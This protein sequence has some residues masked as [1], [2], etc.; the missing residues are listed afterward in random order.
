MALSE[1]EELEL[2]QL[3]KA[4]QGGKNPSFQNQIPDVIKQAGEAALASS[5]SNLTQKFMQT[6]PAVMQKMGGAALP[7]VGGA[8]GGAP[9]AAGGEFLR[10]MTGTALAPE[11]VPQTPL[12]RFASVVGAGAA[13]EPKILEAIPGVPAVKEMASGLLSKVGKG[14]AKAGQTLT[15]AKADVLTQAAKQGLSTYAAPSIPKAQE[16]FGQALGPEGRAAL[17]QSASEA[18]DSSLSKA[19]QLAT[20][21]GTK[22]EKGEPVSAIEALQAK[23]ATDQIISATSVTDKVSRRALFDWKSRFDD[24]LSSQNGPLKSASNTYRQAVVK[25]Q[26]LSPT[27]LNKSGEPSAFLPMLIGHGMMGK[28]IEGGL[29]MLTGTSPA[30]W[31]LGATAGGSAS[32]GLL[33]LGQQPEIRQAL[34]GILQKI[35][36]SR[37]N[38]QAQ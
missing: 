11:T 35:M 28:G 29:G 23:Q 36:A 32:R 30:M 16:I 21:I 37:Q 10:Q 13:Q 26:L 17:K 6:D 31:G 15:G 3:Q 27:R 34:L 7:I 2:L 19:R 12:G 33:K 38:G 24:I 1:S 20:E 4:K 18:F 22:I 9:G 25:D 5:P 14:L 8:L